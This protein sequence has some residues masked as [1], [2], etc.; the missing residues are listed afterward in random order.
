[1][2]SSARCGTSRLHFLDTLI[3]SVVRP[4]RRKRIVSGIQTARSPLSKCRKSSLAGSAQSSKAD[5]SA[6][7]ERGSEK[8]RPKSSRTSGSWRR[9]VALG[10]CSAWASRREATQNP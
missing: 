6:N 1:M 8:L 9:Q 10:M 3:G 2:S 4:L 7:S 5:L